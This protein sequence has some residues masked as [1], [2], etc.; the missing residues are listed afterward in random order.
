M[1]AQL[2][3]Y[4]SMKPLEEL[5]EN[6]LTQANS[7]ALNPA[8]HI[9]AELEHAAVGVNAGASSVSKAGAALA[10]IPPEQSIVQTTANF[11]ISSAYYAS[12]GAASQMSGG[13]LNEVNYPEDAPQAVLPELGLG[14]VANFAF[15]EH[16]VP[17]EASAQPAARMS[18]P[19][20][21][22]SKTIAQMPAAAQ[23]T[24]APRR[25]AAEA[26]NQAAPNKQA[27][28]TVLMMKQ[29]L[30]SGQSVTHRGHLVI[31]G[32][33]NPGAELVAD[34]D[35]TVWGAL[36]G[37]AHAGASGNAN[38]EIRALKFDAIQLRIAN[39][40]A[41]SPDRHKAG[42]SVPAGPETARVIDGKIRLSVSDPE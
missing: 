37:F 42:S 40:I 9:L 31:I 41:R 23:Q 28:P 34:G 20:H 21:Q 14:S 4:A 5:E 38:A 33:V 12:G 24:V 3:G 25:N 18:M 2:Q 35:I 1:L 7:G 32:D 13:N 8:V 39:A 29:T 22:V 19:N 11:A 30:R 17:G 36:R 26:A 10:S 16:S 15:L 27:S 6:P